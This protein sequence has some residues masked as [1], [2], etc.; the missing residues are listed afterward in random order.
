[1]KFVYDVKDMNTFNPV[2]Y[3][4]DIIS[5][6]DVEVTM[7]EATVLIVPKGG[8][9]NDSKYAFIIRNFKEASRSDSDPQHGPSIKLRYDNIS[10]LIIIPTMPIK[11]DS[12][13][14]G[15]LNGIPNKI[16]NSKIKRIVTNVIYENQILI[17]TYWFCNNDSILEILYRLIQNIED[18]IK[19]GKYKKTR[20]PK[21]EE[22]LQEDLDNLTDKVRKELGDDKIKLYIDRKYS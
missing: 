1:M 18:D 16:F 4:M 22:E 3:T 12:K 10:Y 5:T 19:T 17:L 15:S 8:N 13:L 2:Y 21:S 20:Y 9:V 6:F 11:P 7:D 14:Y